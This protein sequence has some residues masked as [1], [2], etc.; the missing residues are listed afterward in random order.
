MKTLLLV[1]SGLGRPP[2]S[3][4]KR[5]EE[6]DQFPRTSLFN[7]VLETDVLDENYFRNVAPLKSLLYKR[8]PV[9]FAQIIEAFFIK[10][11]YDAVISWSERLG[12]M[13]ALLLKLTRSTVPHIT[14]FSW[15][16]NGR[17]GDV[18]RLVHS[19]IDRIILMSSV[20]REYA[21]H[22]IGIPSS[23]ISLLKWPVDTLFW[24]PM[25]TTVDMVCSVGREMRDYE[26]LV[27]AI[28][29]L[30]IPCHIA[31]AS[32]PGK[33][34]AWTESLKRAGPLP[35]HI[36]VGKKTYLELRELYARSLFLIMPILPTDT[37]NGTTS[38]LE[39]MAMGKTVICSKVKGQADVI[40]DGETGFF[41][42]QGDVNAL[43]EKIEYLWSHPDVAAE[44]GRKARLFVEKN[45]RLENYVNQ[46]KDIVAESIALKKS[47]IKTS[48]K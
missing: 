23:K 28:R 42:P 1:T 8:L 47:K 26:T 43:K 36:T 24:R 29:D 19:H 38:I 5:L 33:K 2:K 3:E 4:M 16:S 39:A 30:Q 35:S 20:Q 46:V 18:L 14:L 34:D 31:A 25:E 12:T 7:Q 45:H 10:K 37:D 13:L 6:S 21:V 17:K 41:V 48:E 9:S 44:M 32:F 27:H 15:I 40:V 22:T 11:N